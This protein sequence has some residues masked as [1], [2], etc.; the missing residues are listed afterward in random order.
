MIADKGVADAATAKSAADGAQADV[1]ALE[2]VVG[3]DDTKG[4]RKKVADNTAAIA[5]LNGTGAGSVDKKVTDAINAFANKVTENGTIDTFKELVDWV[6]AHPEIVDGLTGDI[7]KLNAIVDGI[8]G[9]GEK[10]TVVEYVTDA[11]AALKIGDYAKAADLANAISRITTL[12]GKPAVN[13]T[14]EQI[15]SWNGK[16]DQSAYDT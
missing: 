15:A 16:V 4:L 11:I 13:I 5:T 7:T 8:G 6:A 2:E 1:D 12:E 14:A 10:A 3:A 9:E